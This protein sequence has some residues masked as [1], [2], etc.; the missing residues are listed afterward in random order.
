MLQTALVRLRNCQC[1]SLPVVQNGTLM[2]LV[3]ADHLGE[4]LLIQ[5]ALRRTRQPVADFVTAN[6]TAGSRSVRPAVGYGPV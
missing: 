3:T 4:V 1:H 2:G 6:G 5:Q